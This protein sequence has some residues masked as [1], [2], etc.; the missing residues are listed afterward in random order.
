MLAIENSLRLHSF[1]RKQKANNHVIQR[2]TGGPFSRLL[3]SRSPV[4][5]DHYRSAITMSF[6][7]D[8]IESWLH[9]PSEP[10]AGPDND[11]DF[12]CWIGMDFTAAELINLYGYDRTIRNRRDDIA[13][14]I[15]YRLE[16]LVN[17]DETDEDD[18]AAKLGPASRKQEIQ[19][20]VDFI[21]DRRQEFDDADER[22]GLG[23]G[24][25]WYIEPLLE[26]KQNNPM[27]PSGEVGRLEVDDQSSPPADR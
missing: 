3:A 20:L 5:A 2:R 26:K 19:L 10:D 27:Q 12:F 22:T 16:C 23:A 8:R 4:P 14:A 24:F 6:T 17:P 18:V 21:F 1:R 15:C 7:Y 13:L 11:Q 9:D 25:E